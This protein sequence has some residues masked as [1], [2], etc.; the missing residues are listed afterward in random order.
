[1]LA[2][3]ELNLIKIGVLFHREWGVSEHRNRASISNMSECVFYSAHIKHNY[4]LHIF[5]RFVCVVRT[6]AF[7]RANGSCLP[8]D[9]AAAAAATVTYFWQHKFW[10]F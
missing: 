5:L 6:F 1:M 2:T 9:T 4:F 8:S 3:Y 7:G 10:N